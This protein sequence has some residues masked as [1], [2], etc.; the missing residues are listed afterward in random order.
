MARKT[1]HC[2]DTYEHGARGKLALL[3][4]REF[5][6]AEEAVQRAHYIAVKVV[7]VL[8]YSIDADHEHED[9]SEPRILARLGE[10]PEE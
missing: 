5:K 6:T 1:L 4:H 7:G 9:Y 3:D 8:A 10:T 2:V